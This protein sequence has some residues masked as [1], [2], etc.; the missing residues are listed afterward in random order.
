MTW[1]GVCDASPARASLPTSLSVSG[2]PQEQR[3][4]I[5]MLDTDQNQN[6][7]LGST[8][9]LAYSGNAIG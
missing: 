3:P 1:F 9:T 7:C 2:I 4:Q 8:P 5:E 6:G